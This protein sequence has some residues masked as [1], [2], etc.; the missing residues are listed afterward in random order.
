MDE[1]RKKL[2]EIFNKDKNITIGDTSKSSK[3]VVVGKDHKGNDIVVNTEPNGGLELSP[4]MI[5]NINNPEWIKK[6][7]EERRRRK[8]LLDNWFSGARISGPGEDFTRGKDLFEVPKEFLHMITEPE[9][10]DDDLDARSKSI[11]KRARKHSTVV[12]PELMKGLDEGLDM[13]VNYKN[14][15]H[16]VDL[17]KYAKQKNIN[18]KMLETSPAAMEAL[19]KEWKDLRRPSVPV[20]MQRL[21]QECDK[22]FFEWLDSP[23]ADGLGDEARQALRRNVNARVEFI[24][25][26]EAESGQKIYSMED[27]ILLKFQFQEYGL[28]E[29]DQEWFNPHKLIPNTNVT[30]QSYFEEF[31]ER[32]RWDFVDIYTHYWKE[33]EKEK[34]IE[35]TEGLEVDKVNSKSLVEGKENESEILVSKEPDL[36]TKLK[37]TTS[38]DFDDLSDDDII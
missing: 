17:M 1:N 8:E 22:I 30:M 23:S 33:V 36:L 27:F 10:E 15:T 6:N 7:Q 29:E 5:D 24:K 37:E 2:D 9:D 34:S 13:A 21:I 11:I 25:D 12:E 3:L 28:H 32:T 20:I 26:A 4:E 14:M 16:V 35:G 38:E 18:W 31:K 19:Y